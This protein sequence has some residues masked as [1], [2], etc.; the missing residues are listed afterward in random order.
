[1]LI[2]DPSIDLAPAIKALSTG[3]VIAYPTEAVFG[4]GCNP[5]DEA[6]LRRIIEIKGR[7]AHK[8]FIL[9]ASTQSQLSDFIAPLSDAHISGTTALQSAA[10]VRSAMGSELDAIV[11]AAVGD[12]G[13]PTTI[14]DLQSGE[15]LR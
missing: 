15:R 10:S 12:L 6:A 11:D 2:T 5:S 3:G 7:D 14:I 9:I 8:G 4:L 1:V 13:S